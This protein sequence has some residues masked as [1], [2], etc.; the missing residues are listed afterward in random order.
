M[1]E[2]GRR[3]EPD[4]MSLIPQVLVVCRRCRIS[5]CPKQGHVLKN[6]WTKGDLEFKEINSQ[7]SGTSD[8]ELMAKCQMLI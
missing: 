3:Q 1:E 5:Y 2:F 6:W 4:I 7:I 8:P